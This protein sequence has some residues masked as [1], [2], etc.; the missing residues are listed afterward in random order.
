MFAKGADHTSVHITC[1][2]LFLWLLQYLERMTF[3]VVNQIFPARSISAIYLDFY[4]I[5][6]KIKGNMKIFPIMILR[7]AKFY[8]I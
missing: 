2:R 1:D 7:N 8:Q 4:N 6:N 5:V 3:N